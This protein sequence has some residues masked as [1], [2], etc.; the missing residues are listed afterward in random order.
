[1]GFRILL[2]AALVVPLLTTAAS[3]TPPRLGSQGEVGNANAARVLAAW[4]PL[5][6]GDRLL[7]QWRDA[8]TPVSI[9]LVNG[10][11]LQ[12]VITGFD[13]STLL[14]TND[15]ATQLVYKHAISTIVPASA[16]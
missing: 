6:V 4:N 10:I 9:F 3:A 14:L 7:K 1:M 8:R 13:A 15:S 11:K 5:N 12:G 2:A 16:P